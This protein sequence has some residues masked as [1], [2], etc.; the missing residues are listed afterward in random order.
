MNIIKGI[1]LIALAV[2]TLISF[3]CIRNCKISGYDIVKGFFSN[4]KIYPYKGD[5]KTCFVVKGKKNYFVTTKA[6]EIYTIEEIQ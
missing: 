5:P 2:I 3:S 1:I 4:S 6:N